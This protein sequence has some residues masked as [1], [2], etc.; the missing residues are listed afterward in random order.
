MQIYLEND[1]RI[2][3]RPDTPMD[4]FQLGNIYSAMFKQS[5]KGMISFPDGGP[6]MLIDAKQLNIVDELLDW[7]GTGNG[8][9][10]RIHELLAIEA[11]YHQLMVEQ[12]NEAATD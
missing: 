6:D 4:G 7:E 9:V 5:W 11:K 12:A 1:H 10:D 3:L 2:R 8:R